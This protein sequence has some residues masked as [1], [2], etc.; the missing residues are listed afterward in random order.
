MCY[1][2]CLYA[3][4]VILDG[5]WALDCLIGRP[6]IKHD[7]TRVSLKMSPWGFVTRQRIIFSKTKK[8]TEPVFRRKTVHK[9]QNEMRSLNFSATIVMQQRCIRLY[10]YHFWRPTIIQKKNRKTA[11]LR[12]NSFVELVALTNLDLLSS[13]P[14]NMH[15]FM[16]CAHQYTSIVWSRVNF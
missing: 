2:S 7:E 13:P 16:R 4:V 10:K 15:I 11:C 9:C 14:V 5:L 6:F 12:L 1:I 8:A 3:F